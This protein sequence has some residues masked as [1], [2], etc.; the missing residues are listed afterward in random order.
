M[1][2]K[3]DIRFAFQKPNNAHVQ[4]VLV[5]V[6]VFLVMN[7]L[8]ILSNIG[9]TDI[10]SSISRTLFNLPANIEQFLYKPWTII[11]YG[12][13][14]VEIFHI[15][16]NMMFLY[17][18]GRVFEDFLGNRRFINL[19][20]LGAIAGGLLYLICYNTIPFYTERT[21]LYGMI[22][23]SAAVN[24][25][26]VGAATLTPNFEFRLFLL[27][28]V[29]L[30]YIAMFLVVTSFLQVDGGNAG[31]NIAHLGG[32]AIG[33]LFVKMLQSGTDLGRPLNTVYDF[34]GGLFNPSKRVKVSYK[35]TS[36]A[37]NKSSS[38]NSASKTSQE[39]V[40]AILDKIA[41]SGYESL[42]KSEK[43]KLFNASKD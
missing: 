39:E 42:S 41:E 11:T 29:K 40:D 32:A 4:F 9:G 1:S 24:A 22:G 10:F 43:D 6:A 5:N 12:F 23:A 25:I 38:N 19:Y 16:S 2:I 14:H 30:K 31:G 37:G 28:N 26:V 15:L 7:T 36:T 13:A 21:P 27:G 17:F 3:D 35:K 18:V 20:I 33:Y 34:F 8:R